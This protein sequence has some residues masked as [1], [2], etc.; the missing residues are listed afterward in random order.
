MADPDVEARFQNFI[1]EG[2]SRGSQLRDAFAQL[3]AMGQKDAVP[4]EA[5]WA[6]QGQNQLHTMN[7]PGDDIQR[8]PL[9]GVEGLGRQAPMPQIQ[10]VDPM[11]EFPTGT[12]PQDPRMKGAAIPF[13]GAKEIEVKPVPKGGDYNLPKKEKKKKDKG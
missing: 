9:M 6:A 2:G 8:S 13:P 5:L 10:T 7:P 11:L 4:A 12:P 3:L 1:S